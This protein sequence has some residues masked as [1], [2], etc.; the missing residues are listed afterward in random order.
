MPVSAKI[1]FATAIA[2]ALVG[3]ITGT[4]ALTKRSQVADGE[5]PGNMCPP[6]SLGASDLNAAHAWATAANIAFAVGAAGAMVG[7]IGLL[8]AGHAD[9][10]PPNARAH[11]A[12][13]IG[14]GAVGVHGSF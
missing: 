7:L 9:P 2:G 12:P 8:T 3:A 5:C 11:A 6:N 14:L 13:W 1:G 10:P 4:T